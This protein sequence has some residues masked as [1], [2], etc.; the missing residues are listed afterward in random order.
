MWGK[1]FVAA[2]HRLSNALFEKK[3]K[4]CQTGL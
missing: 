2:M 3:E 4:F 1:S